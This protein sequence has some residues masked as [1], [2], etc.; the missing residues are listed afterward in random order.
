M[1]HIEDSGSKKTKGLKQD[2]QYRLREA[3][4]KGDEY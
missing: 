3:M 4:P 1:Q 2:I